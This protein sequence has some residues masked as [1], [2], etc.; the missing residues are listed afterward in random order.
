MSDTFELLKNII[1]RGEYGSRLSSYGEQWDENPHRLLIKALSRAANRSIAGVIDLA[2]LIRHLLRHQDERLGGKIPPA[3]RVP[4]RFP[5]PVDRETWQRCGMDILDETG[6]YFVVCARPWLPEWLNLVDGH[7]PEKQAFAETLLR[8]YSSVPGD[9]FLSLVRQ[10]SY[11]SIGQREAIRAVLTAPNPSTL[12]INLPTGSGKS[13][14]AGLPALLKSGTGGVSIIIVPTTAL[15]LDQERALQP[16]I[17]HPTAYYND[18]SEAGQKRRRSI[19]ERIRAGTQCVVFTSPESLMNSLAPHVYEAARRGLFRYFVIDEAHIVE[20]W[21]D[22]F[23][24][25]FQE[26]AGLRK[27]L[28]KFTSFNTLL[29]TATLTESCLDTLEILFG[30][31][32]EFQVISAVQLRPEPSYWFVKCADE[33]IRR[34]RLLEAVHHLPRPL[35]IY[36]S[37]REDVRRWADEL[38]RAGFKRYGVMTGESKP[39]EREQLIQ[40]WCEQNIDIVVATSAFGMGIDRADVRAVIHACIPESVDRFYQE[41]GRAG[42]DGKAAISLTLYTPEDYKTA[43]ALNE[44]STI[45]IDRGLQRWE[46]MFDRKQVLTHGRY[47]VPIDVPPSMSQGD[48]DMNSQQNTDWNSRTLTLMCQAGLIALEGEPP[49]QRVNFTSD[50]EY[51]QARD[52]HHN[53]RIIRI[54]NESHLQPY[55]WED[56]V[57]PRRAQRQTLNHQSL[58]LMKEA[59]GKPHRCLSEIFEETYTIATRKTGSLRKGV[60]VSRACGGCPFC[61][62]RRTPPFSRIMPRP[63]PVWQTPNFFLGQ[64]LK[65]L[66]SGEKTILIF[67]DHLVWHNERQQQGKVIRWLID[68][69]IN[70]VVTLGETRDILRGMIDRMPHRDALIL[71]FDDYKPITMSSLPTLIWHAPGVPIPTSYLHKREHPSAYRVILLP[72]DSRDPDRDDRRLSDIFNGRSFRFEVFCKEIGL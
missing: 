70:N 68:R 5:Y 42:R 9:P 43:A 19:R 39:G 16:L 1:D 52:A 59:L 63:L 34:E 50:R 62:G 15:A 33:D 57:E 37:K 21:G 38:A 27:D 72:S 31:G 6:E 10:D 61:R 23:R 35:I 17:G 47:R 54:L 51:Q 49:P 28:L 48:I 30:G 18:E 58:N 55:I 53:S 71:W 20:Q 29:L 44:K 67:Y 12:M 24:P 65:R 64:E 66:F 4:R 36:T 14:C 25:E 40:D 41:V 46:S 45:T 3:L 32:S 26:I 2:G 56:V 60:L 13:L 8:N 7:S 22:G 69:G 11:R